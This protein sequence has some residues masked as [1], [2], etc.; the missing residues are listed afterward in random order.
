MAAW[1]LSAKVVS[2]E[3]RIGV[4]NVSFESGWRRGSGSEAEEQCCLKVQGRSGEREWRNRAHD[5]IEAMDRSSNAGA[6]F[7]SSD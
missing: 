4:W 2:S 6:P 5:L 7:V 3:D 1:S